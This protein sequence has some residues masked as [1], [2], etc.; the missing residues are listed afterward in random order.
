MELRKINY[1]HKYL[2]CRHENL[3]RCAALLCHLL[4]RYE[5]TGLKLVLK[6]EQSP[7]KDSSNLGSIR[8]NSELQPLS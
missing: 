1:S 8:H 7:L 6:N 2:P 3:K 4:K 5:E